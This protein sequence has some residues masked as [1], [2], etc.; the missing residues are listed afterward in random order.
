MK[1]LITFLG[2]GEY[3]E[4]IYHW[5]GVDSRQRFFALAAAEWEE[6]AEIY[7]LLTPE[8]E[9]HRNW[10]GDETT[11]GL[12]SDPRCRAV[13]IT[14]G[15]SEKEM[16]AN[17]STLTHLFTL[18]AEIVLDVTHAFR[19]LPILGLA[20]ASYAR[21]LSGVTVTR[22]LYGAYEA[23][24]VESGR[25]PVFDLGVFLQLLDWTSAAHLLKETGDA[26]PFGH[27]LSGIQQQARQP[28]STPDP[29][30]EL[31]T[32]LKPLG[33]ALTSLSEAL[34]VTRPDETRLK[35]RDLMIKIQKARPQVE[36]WAPPFAAALEVVEDTFRDLEGDGLATER[37]I[38]SWYV[39]HG[40]WVQ[41]LTLAR[42]WLVSLTAAY[43]SPHSDL[44]RRSSREPAEEMLNHAV[45]RRSEAI[46]GP[47]SPLLSNFDAWLSAAEV[48]KLWS[49]IRDL[50]NDLA[51]CGMN[52][53]PA[54]AKA[55]G[56][57]VDE[58][59][60]RLSMLPICCSDSTP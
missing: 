14:S 49:A 7:V 59:C 41:A 30:S 37:S 33:S 35:A 32:L 29:A 28:G 52:E 39:R 15:K 12:A 21:A 55:V 31:P 26:R 57:R 22:I 18:D 10:I 20:A 24:N 44:R 36:T 56:Q 34:M 48:E 58:L 16:W 11:P 40:H 9:N 5:N 8:A 50:R 42:E 47:A 3:K 54:Q 23:R 19:S 27:I 43:L 38:I 1:R 25:T 6:P 2:T 53:Q 17:F 46:R 60:K 51:H 13:P 45:I 4:V